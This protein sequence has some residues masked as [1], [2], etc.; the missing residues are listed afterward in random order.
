MSSS[1]ATASLKN[2]DK[3]KLTWTDRK[4]DVFAEGIF[5]PQYRRSDRTVGWV[6]VL[7]RLALKKSS[8]VKMFEEIKKTL[9]KE[10]QARKMEVK[11]L[12]STA[13]LFLIYRQAS[14]AQHQN[15][16]RVIN[17]R[18]TR[19]VSVNKIFVKISS[20]YLY[21]DELSV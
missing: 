4:T 15:T 6:T 2:K 12:T 11:D 14:S 20:S 7:E 9:K 3:T 13:T 10:F 16:S 19:N 5:D 8:N 18:A 17:I 21:L 1:K